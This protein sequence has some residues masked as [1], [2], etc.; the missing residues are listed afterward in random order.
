MTALLLLVQRPF[1][2]CLAIAGFASLGMTTGAAAVGIALMC[3]RVTFDLKMEQLA[4]VGTAEWSTAIAATR[5]SET[6]VRTAVAR[7][8]SPRDD[9]KHLELPLAC[10]RPLMWHGT[11]KE[12]KSELNHFFFFVSLVVIAP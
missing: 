4:M 10:L 9:A 8:S 11:M 6:L 1:P 5:T 3:M 2:C 7:T 12:K